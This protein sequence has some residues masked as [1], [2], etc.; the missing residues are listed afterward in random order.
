M[1]VDF[2]ETMSRLQVGT[3]TLGGNWKRTGGAGKVNPFRLLA[4]S[5]VWTDGD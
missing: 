3:Q 2:C 4:F 5:M 1:F